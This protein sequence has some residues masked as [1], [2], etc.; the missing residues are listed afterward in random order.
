M[1]RSTLDQLEEAKAN[2]GKIFNQA[3]K[4]TMKPYAK[5]LH[6]IQRDAERLHESLEELGTKIAREATRE[7]K[8]GRR[9]GRKLSAQARKKIAQ[10]MKKAWARRKSL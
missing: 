5:E 6:A 4:E 9:E 1:A 10:A 7:F 3:L 2:M 8:R